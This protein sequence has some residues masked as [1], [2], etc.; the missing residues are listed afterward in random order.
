[1]RITTRTVAALAIITASTATQAT[2]ISIVNASFE[3]DAPTVGG[4]FFFGNPNGWQL[5]DQ[6]GIIDGNLD[7]QGTLHVTGG[8]YF[9]G[10]AP[11]QDRVAILFIGTDVGGGEVGL[12]QMLGDTLAA[13][14]HYSL[15]VDVGNI[16]T[17]L[18][19]G[20]TLF[21]LDGFPGYRIQ[22]LAGTDVIA[23]VADGIDAPIGE[24]VFA[25]VTLDFITGAVHTN[26]G[27][28]LGIRLINRNLVNPAIVPGPGQPD[29]D[30]EVDFDN[31]RLD[32]TAVPEPATVLL[33]GATL[34][35]AVGRRRRASRAA[36]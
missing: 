34:L 2:P 16:D 13:N 36:G 9:G 19:Q 27:Q 14:T 33:V 6:N 5:Y 7:V 4:E 29:V 26:L 18:T 28:N 22:L 3:D 21:N 24:G 10:V 15:T 25:P 32:A 17:G 35:P 8:N 31:V 11:D 23:E 30:L 1:M 20:G 12:F